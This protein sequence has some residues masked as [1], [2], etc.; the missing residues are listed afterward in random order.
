M[1]QQDHKDQHWIPRSYTKAWADKSLP[2]S[3]GSRIHIYD[4]IGN[5]AGWKYPPQLFTQPE[6]Y[7]ITT[8]TGQR[9]LRAEKFL[10]RIESDF[11][12]VRR[13][14]L[15]KRQPLEARHLAAITIFVAALRS[16]TPSSHSNISGFWKSV[17]ATGDRV[18]EQMA[19]ASPDRRE[20][21]A[22]ALSSP[23]ASQGDRSIT[24]DEA[25]TIAGLVPGETMMAQVAVEAPLLAH[26]HVCVLSTDCDFGFITSDRP[27]VWWDPTQVGG[28]H[29]LF[30]VG[31]A[32]REI[33]I[34]IPIS[35]RQ[36]LL[37]SHNHSAPEYATVDSKVRD[38]INLRT[39]AYCEEK[40]LSDFA[41]LDVDWLPTLGV[42]VVLGR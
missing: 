20:K 31:L 19:A 23:L 12:R 1:T 2:K 39:L 28:R 24:L 36:C 32:N 10:S 17:V 4:P 40:W 22:R 21:I 41:T 9:D 42:D 8:P 16:R 18:A 6:F 25:R 3:L 5:Y 26:L 15:E 27:V 30:G 35:P 13:S 7:T 33:E 38:A 34:T 37:F 11:A 14:T 29:R